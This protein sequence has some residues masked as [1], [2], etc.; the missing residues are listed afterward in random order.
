[1]SHFGEAREGQNEDSPCELFAFL[2][3]ADYLEESLPHLLVKFLFLCTIMRL[4]FNLI[5][6]LI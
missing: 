3:G 6:F 2:G 5:D 4:H 1:M